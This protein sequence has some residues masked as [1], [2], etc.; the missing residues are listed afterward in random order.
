[1]MHKVYKKETE[2]CI[3]MF[4][5]Y[6][7]MHIFDSGIKWCFTKVL[8]AKSIISSQGEMSENGKQYFKLSHFMLL[9]MRHYGKD[10]AEDSLRVRVTHTT[11]HYCQGGNLLFDAYHSTGTIKVCSLSNQFCLGSNKCVPHFLHKLHP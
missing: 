8:E 11:S 3:F 4:I 9:L 7:Q 6:C 10:P 5:K 2:S 1:M